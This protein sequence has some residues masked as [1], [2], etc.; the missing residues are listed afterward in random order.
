MVTTEKEEVLFFPDLLNTAQLQK[1]TGYTKN[2]YSD[3]VNMKGFP[4][5]EDGNGRV[6]YPRDGVRQF[7]KAKTQYNFD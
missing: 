4:K 2:N 6:K 3:L 7:I 5:F 1:M